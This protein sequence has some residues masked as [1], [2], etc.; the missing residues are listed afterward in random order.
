[1]N[2]ERYDALLRRYHKWCS[3]NA[4]EFH[5]D[6]QDRQRCCMEMQSLTKE[7]L[8]AFTE[9]DFYNLMAPLWS[10]AMWGN[11]HYKI[12]Q[13]VEANGIDLIRKELDYLLYG[14][15]SI[16][17][18]WDRFRDK[19]KGVGPAAMSEILN[20]FAPDKYILW[21]SKALNGFNLLEIEKVPKSAALIDGKKY[22]YLC[23]QGQALVK[24]AQDHGVKEIDNLLAL[25]YLIWQEMQDINPDTLAEE[26]VVPKTKE[27]STFVHNDVRDRIRDIGEL[28]GFKAGT[29]KKIADGAVVDAIWEVTVSNMGRITYVF[30]VQTK[31]SIDSLLL[32]LLKSKNNSSVQGVV[33][34]S[35]AA[36]IETIRKEAAAVKGL[37]D[38][39]FW[40]Y[41]EVLKVYENLS[42]AFESINALGLVPSGLTK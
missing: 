18:R 10:M 17:K 20:K 41:N 37:E 27:E 25:N 30:E 1:M 13:I 14:T 16:I 2:K 23:K 21:N 28:L 31:G 42:N 40:D 15:D 8:A 19:I 26:T 34:V 5:E 22:E 38:L 24:Y 33:A 39:K 35:D 3:N 7:Q 12:D 4:K 6:V 29:E 11:K 36:Q 32:N 9:E